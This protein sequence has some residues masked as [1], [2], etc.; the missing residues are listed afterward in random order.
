MKRNSLRYQ[1]IQLTV[2]MIVVL[3]FGNFKVWN[4]YDQLQ[5]SEQEKQRYIEASLAFKDVR[6]HIVGI[7]QFISD[8]ATIGA[9]DYREAEAEKQAAQ[10]DLKK[11][12]G[13]AP[14]MHSEL[15]RLNTSVEALYGTGVL[16]ADAYFH[17]GRE[18][19]NALM[20]GGD[21]SFDGRVETLTGQLDQT[22][23]LLLKRMSQTSRMQDDMSSAMFQAS[24]WVAGLAVFLVM[25]AN[26]WLGRKIFT[27]V[28]GEPELAAE[29]AQKIADGDLSMQIK[30]QSG[31]QHSVLAKMKTMV[32]SI[33]ALVHDAETLS[34]AGV[35]GALST[36]ADARLHKGEFRK[37]VEGVNNTLDAVIGP[38]TVAADC[39]ENIAKGNIPAKIVDHYNGDFNVI[40]NNLNICIDA[41]NALVND[42]IMLSEAAVDGRLQTRA[43]VSKHQGDYRKIVEGV[44][45]TLD[46]ILL[47]LDEAIIV[48]KA[49][50]QGDMTRTITGGY[51]GQLSDF[52]HTVNNT[53]GKLSQTI[54][55]V[56]EA[57]H[58]LSDASSQISATSQSLSQSASVQAASVEETSASIE[59]MAASV[60]QNAENA[61]I[62]DSMAGKAAKEAIEGGVAVRETLGAMKDIATKIGIIDD[63][64]YQ[65]NMLALNA[66]IEAARAGHH[67]KGFAVAEDCCR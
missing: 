22:G 67:G 11:L 40:K 10:R 62:T 6:Y 4:S 50:E 28:G 56:V 14:E 55:D 3:L 64:A 20:K 17:K 33:Q 15:D 53:V 38:L 7:Q 39:V 34:T 25:A 65:T 60:G 52:K 37:V 9:N 63:I 46:G 36:R 32:G 12:A 27:S 57:T 49:V 54:A 18:A 26:F 29:I 51:A 35:N 30:L 47:P 44:N 8:A 31:D 2:V 59:Q 43:D 42:A 19:G 45:A 58:H 66:A 13:I 16:M 23:E 21:D 1:M 5:Q 41:I 48:L 61:A 24:S